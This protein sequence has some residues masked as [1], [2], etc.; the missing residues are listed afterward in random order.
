MYDDDCDDFEE[1]GYCDECQNTGTVGC[2]C[3]GDLCVCG[4]EELPCPRC[5]P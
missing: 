2:Y 5:H 4:E 1:P 3:G